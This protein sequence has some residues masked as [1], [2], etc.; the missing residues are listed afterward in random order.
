MARL[1]KQPRKTPSQTSA[2]FKPRPKA[3]TKTSKEP[4]ASG[5]VVKRRERYEGRIQEHWGCS[6]QEALPSTSHPPGGMSVR[7]LESLA[8]LAQ[9]CEKDSAVSAIVKKAQ[10][11]TRATAIAFRD[12][13]E[14]LNSFDTT[15]SE[16]NVETI[17]SK[18]KRADSVS[19]DGHSSDES[20]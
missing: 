2:S 3:S 7:A 14:A 8:L 19:E 9:H 17:S 6:W 16:T 5:Q 18:R 15:S 12:I 20:S 13:H 4:T 10:L 11:R 1:R